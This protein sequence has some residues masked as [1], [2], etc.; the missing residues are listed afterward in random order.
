[1][2]LLEDDADASK[3]V[4]VLTICK[5]LF[6]YIYTHTHICTYIHTHICSLFYQP[7]IFDTSRRSSTRLSVCMGGLC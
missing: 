5:I 4:G 1:M 7:I 3:H 6:I 2:R